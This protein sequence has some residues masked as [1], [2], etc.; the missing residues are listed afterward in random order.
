MGTKKWNMIIDVALCHDCNNCFL[1]DKDEFVGNDFPPYSVA[2]P[3]SGHRW[4]NIERKERGQFP[5]VQVAYLPIPCMH[6]GDAPCMKASPEGTI[7]RREDGLVI[8]DPQKAKGH[9][10]IVGTCP[11]GVIYWNEEAQVAQKCTGCAHLMDEGWTETRCS[12]VCPTGAIKLVLAED[13]DMAKVMKDEGLQAFKAELDTQPRT[14]YKNLYKWEK[15]F[16][17]GSAVYKDTDE[18]AEGA[19]VTVSSGGAKVGAG[20]ANNYSEFVID[21]LEPGKEYVV[22]VEAKGYQPYVTTVKPEAS[23]NLG[24]LFLEK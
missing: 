4:M 11:Y 2:Q 23:I 3:W 21:K 13:A 8:I 15:I 10:E 1:A 5:I 7:Y 12:Q 18:C 20:L 14:L 17:S 9:K 6:C 24:V 19:E 16:V 22:T